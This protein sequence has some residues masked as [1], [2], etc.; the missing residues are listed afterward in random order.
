MSEAHMIEELERQRSQIMYLRRQLDAAG[1][2]VAKEVRLRK[3][4]EAMAFKPIQWSD[5]AKPVPLVITAIDRGTLKEWVCAH[6]VTD[7][8]KEMSR[9]EAMPLL[10]RESIYDIARQIMEVVKWD[11][12]HDGKGRVSRS[13]MRLF[14]G[15]I[16]KDTP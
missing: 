9:G 1:E 12:S 4:A 6:Y 11:R 7:Q 10:E 13:Q 2:Y 14:I 16:P 15:Y 5:T 3:A 8:D